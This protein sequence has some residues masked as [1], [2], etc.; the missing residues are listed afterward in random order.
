M[1]AHNIGTVSSIPPC[2]TIKTLL[3]WKATGNH[4]IKS[5]SLEKT[6]S[7]VSGCCCARNRVCDAEEGNGIPPHKIHSR[8][9]SSEP[10]LVAAALEI[11]YATQLL[12]RS[13]YLRIFFSLTFDSCYAINYIDQI[14]FNN[15]FPIGFLRL[16]K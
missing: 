15:I 12:L 2:I 14:D 4:L 5:T 1:W 7:P 6:Q 8:R 9:K 11:E 13:G 16:M 10:C 3:F